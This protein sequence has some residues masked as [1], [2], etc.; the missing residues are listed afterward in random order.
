MLFRS[1]ECKLKRLLNKWEKEE[2]RSQLSMAVR[3]VLYMNE[4]EEDD[5]ELWSLARPRWV[6]LAGTAQKK[7][8]K[9]EKKTE[10][11]GGSPLLG[12]PGWVGSL[13]FYPLPFFIFCFS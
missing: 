13:F 4:H 1:V 10:G 6:S 9:K 11:S 3:F 8:G 2:A 7:I 12:R 5:Q